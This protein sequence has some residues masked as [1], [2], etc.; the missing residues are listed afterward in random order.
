MKYEDF[1][2]TTREIIGGTPKE[3]IVKALI[4]AMVAFWNNLTII[5]MSLFGFGVLLFFDALLGQALA[6]RS[7][8]M[9]SFTRFM[10]GPVKKLLLTA[11][12]FLSTSIVDGMLNQVNLMPDSPL[13]YGAAVFISVTQLID[14]AR[15]YGTLFNS[16]FANWLEAKLG[17]FVKIDDK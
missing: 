7:G 14:V 5:S 4:A 1:G 10:F 11:V 9:F 17:R 13:F 12:M 15:K 3:V 8:Q 16:K 2:S 6:R